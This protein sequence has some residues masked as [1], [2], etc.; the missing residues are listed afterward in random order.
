MGN[1]YFAGFQS[2]QGNA[3]NAAL[4]SPN[5]CQIL[6][7]S[8]NPGKACAAFGSAPFGA[9]EYLDPI[10]LPSGFASA[11][12]TNLPG[13]VTALASSGTTVLN[14]PQ[15]TTTI[16]YAPYASV[17]VNQ[18]PAGSGNPTLVGDTSFVEAVSW[19]FG[20]SGSSAKPTGNSPSTTSGG[21]TP[22][23]TGSAAAATS[24]KSAASA[25]KTVGLWLLPVAFG[26]TLFL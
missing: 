25:P 24:S 8:S 23:G 20:P 4:A 12:L 21:T 1:V 19:T 3:S 9:K 10:N 13:S 6:R 11:S 2:V 7:A 22:S 5:K 26:A 14:L 16:T 18:G 17:T 15:W